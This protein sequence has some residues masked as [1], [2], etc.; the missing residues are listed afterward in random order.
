MRSVLERLGRLRILPCVIGV[1]LVVG[2]KHYE[3]SLFAGT[4]SSSVVVK[5]RPVT[6]DDLLRQEDYGQALIDPTG[7]WLVFEQTQPYD[8]LPDYG[9]SWSA[10]YP[11]PNFGR[12]MVIDLTA[13]TRPRLLF[14]PEP[15]TQFRIQSFS[16]NGQRLALYALKQGKVRL[17]IYDIR[18][19]RLKT[20]KA[21]PELTFYDTTVVWVSIDEMVFTALT[22]G[23]QPILSLRRYTGTRLF[24]AWNKT[25]EGK[26]PSVNEV[27][28]HSD[29]GGQNFRDGML[30]KA[31]AR[32]GITELLGRGL[33]KDLKASV[34]SQ[35]VAGLR[36][37]DAVQPLPDRPSSSD[38][39]LRFQLVVFDM[40]T[41][42]S[43]AVATEMDVSPG[44]MEWS[45]TTDA[46]G[47][48]AWKKYASPQTGLFYT[49]D[50]RSGQ[51]RAWPHNGLDLA[52]GGYSQIPGQKPQ[53]VAWL[54]GRLAVLARANVQGD[55]TPRFTD[56][57]IAGR[58]GL[59]QGKADW[60]LLNPI[61]GAENLT[62][63]FRS[64][65]PIPVSITAK[66]LCL[67]ADG[68]VWRI[69][70]DGT[71]MNMT[72]GVV[73]SLEHAR[74]LGE[75]QSRYPE[76]NPF[77]AGGPQVAKYVLVDLTGDARMVMIPVSSPRAKLM[78]GS[79]KA[80]IVLV[81]E[82][83]GQGT[84]LL[85]Q[86]ANSQV[87][88]GRL[89]GFFGETAKSEWKVISYGAKDGRTLQSGLLLPYGYTPEKRYPVVV[90]IYP[91]QSPTWGPN[92][93]IGERS[94]SFYA[95]ELLA[96]RGYIV[97]Y[98]ANPTDLIRT[99]DGPINGMA[100]VILR[101]VDA[102]VSQ[103]F[104]DPDR[105]GLIGFSQGGFS[106]L[107]L[108]TETDRFRA[109]VSINGWADMAS[110]YF[111][112]GI[113]RAFY[114]DELPFNGASSRYE[115]ES[116]GD[117]SLGRTPWQDAEVYIRNSPV[118]RADRIKT[119]ILLIHSDMDGFALNQYDEMFTA[120]YRLRKEGRFV[121]YWGEGH[122][123]SSPANIRDMWYRTFAWFDAWSD[124]ERDSKG[125][126]AWDGDKVKSRNGGPPLK[127][128]DFA[129]F[130]RMILTESQTRGAV[131]KNAAKP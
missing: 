46:L 112:G 104:A 1:A 86:S 76:N 81:R 55:E 6:V 16:P 83:T 32:T 39:G 117:F 3:T 45:P 129:R 97:F 111:E 105:I 44:S 107:W 38:M 125:N 34:D 2:A 61:G 84:K 75:A 114:S 15:Q 102:L 63:E 36:Q 100:E 20:L 24:E 51:I 5:H 33:F 85:L 14:E 108:A 115:P 60:F 67:T 127:P 31:N 124:I 126:L 17:V 66:G 28:S 121:R 48:F 11:L 92:L 72:R 42:K 18:S 47:F 27:T 106:S 94:S 103:G 35:F 57:G 49:Y 12:I 74:Y 64:V 53:R 65:S 109:I 116:G 68:N 122:G 19:G 113:Q 22:G 77:T 56:R 119:P 98:V 99:K 30:L 93:V 82:N 37:T 69:A 90:D 7:R 96:A 80:G 130:D 73:G 110:H 29:G 71:K 10:R 23:R 25:W 78:A 123:P 58:S 26:E 87:E 101:G 8:K 41:G 89:N 4:S 54:D 128:T 118:Y 50:A 120:L 9:V 91:A 40:K 43:Q 70:P 13:S 88:V 79:V 21:T 95:R 62:T 59:G 131:I 52:S